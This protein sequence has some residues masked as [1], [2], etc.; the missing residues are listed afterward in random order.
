MKQ[1]CGEG[2]PVLG[3]TGS[4]NL[5]DLRARAEQVFHDFEVHYHSVIAAMQKGINLQEDI[6]DRMRTLTQFPAYNPNPV[7]QV[8]PDGMIRYANVASQHLLK[9]WNCEVGTPVPADIQSLIG[10]VLEDG[11]RCEIEVQ[12]DERYLSLNLAP[13][14]DNALVNIYGLDITER[15][16]I[17]VA[18]RESEEA[19][20]ML[21][22]SA[23]VGIV[24]VN[25]EGCIDMVNTK[26]LEL[27][28]YTS[29]DLIGQ[30]I[31]ILVPDVYKDIHTQQCMKFRSDPH[32]RPMG[33]GMNLTA[34]R[35]DGSSFPVEIS[36]GF[37]RTKKGLVT[38]SFIVDITERQQ[39]EAQREHLM[40]MMVHDLRSPLSST[41]TSLEYLKAITGDVLEGDH[42]K[43]LDIA[44]NSADKMLKLVNAILDVNRLKSGAMPLV[45]N[46]VDLIDLVREVV[47]EMDVLAGEKDI[48]ISVDI[49]SNLP[50]IDVDPG[51][52][53][54]VI[55]NLVNNA[56]KFTPEEGFIHLK[57]WQ[58]QDDPEKLVMSVRDSG[59]GIPLEIRDRLFQEFVTGMQAGR[60]SGLG[61]AFCKLAVGAHAERI[62]V[63][64]EIDAGTAFF[65]T[66]PV[67]DE[68]D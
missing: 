67:A 15:M 27:F 23:P 54:R 59:P 26:A 7:M 28:G 64:S 42:V 60:G 12:I 52:I 66:L 25:D 31:G 16:Q 9:Y 34:K 18:L 49:P 2:K 51:L 36:L 41:L 17:E 21:L 50:P 39:I 33:T 46:V 22:E 57:A 45:R 58:L 20:R 47:D 5:D 1:E 14:S 48:K 11:K 55:Q 53:A 38:M 61:L 40:R 62:W 13:Y 30:S 4:D 35:I 56:I 44:T 63:E 32:V 29:V 37:I 65:F 68:D 10:Q 43:L 3:S 19:T 8:A 24:I 6:E